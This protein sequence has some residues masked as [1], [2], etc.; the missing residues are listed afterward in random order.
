M[1]TPA[2]FLLAACLAPTCLAGFDPANLDP[3]VSPG[4]DFYRYAVG[5]WLRT[6]SIP[7]DR[8]SWGADDELQS[9]NEMILHDIASGA[10]TAANPGFIEKMVGDFYASGMDEKTVDALGILPLRTELD[11]IGS[12]SSVA[13][14][15]GLVARLHSI[16]LGVCFGFGSEQD[17]KDSDRMIGGLGQG[18]LSL[19][20][21]DY[22]LRTD[23]D[24]AKLRDDYVLHAARIF[25]LA[26]DDPASARREADA[27]MRIETALA[28]GSRTAADL[29]DPAA[30]YHATPLADLGKL[31]PHFDFRAYFA[32]IGL[33]A[34]ASVDVGQPEF[35]QAM[36][37]EIASA[38][39]SDW[40]SY[41]RWHLIH[42]NAAYLSA[43][44]ADENFAFFATR[45]SGVPKMR[46]RWHRVVGA[47]DENIGEALG[48]LYVARAFPPESKARMLRLVANLRQAL[49]DR[50]TH[51]DWMDEPT[52]AAA[53]RKLDR[54]GVK[55]GYP[56]KWIDYRSLV[57]DRGPYILN[58]LRANEFSVKRDLAKIGKPVDRTEWG[59]TPPTVNAYYSDSMNEIVF[60]AGYLRPPEF[61]PSADDAVNYGAIGA[62]IGHEMT[63]GFD[64]TGRQFDEKGNLSDWWTKESEKRFNERAARIIRQFGAYVAVDTL[65][66]NGELTQG[67]N[68]A[69]L[70]GL[71]LA[72][73]ALMRTLDGRTAGTIGGFTPAQRFFLSYADA[74]RILQRPE[75]LRVQVNT[76]PHAPNN[77][78]VNG[79]LSNMDEFAAAFHVP[80]G[81]PMRRPAAD[82][83]DIW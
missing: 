31:A 74:Y 79:P 58:I 22:Y 43:P 67:E 45:L 34:P 83:V 47:A 16:G 3:T 77:L 65:H 61:D 53:L 30:N 78:R 38:P 70:G 13:E 6:H 19:P 29:R 52:R 26:G 59:M 68:I 76:D 36:D 2:A 20:D 48:Q 18:G 44:F 54:M 73:T 15:T 21:R 28:K 42:E 72:Y 23:A 27:M 17:S 12:L 35:L 80:E 41:F 40:R 66:V 8:S 57:I 50:I 32:G 71:K 49:R 75:D 10:S 14:V 5:G 56:D 69:D 82:R 1:K 55:I 46:E 64:D 60:P 63:H 81:A 9:S 11:R 25:A 37:A 7:A 33:A 24:S 62:T 4:A 39:L 51:L